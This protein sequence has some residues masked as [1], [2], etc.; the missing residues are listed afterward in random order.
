M[1]NAVLAAAPLPVT[2]AARRNQKAFSSRS[3][4]AVKQLK[5]LHHRLGGEYVLFRVTPAHQCKVHCSAGL[6]RHMQLVSRFISPCAAQLQAFLKN[7]PQEAATPAVQPATAGA[8]G[9]DEGPAPA[10]GADAPAADPH[11]ATEVAAQQPAAPRATA[12]Q[13]RLRASRQ[14]R[15]ALTLAGGQLE[16]ASKAQLRQL[17]E[18]ESGGPMPLGFTARQLRE[19]LQQMQQ[20]HLT[21]VLVNVWQIASTLQAHVGQSHAYL[22]VALGCA[23]TYTLR[24][25]GR[26]GCSSWRRRGRY[27]SSHRHCVTLPTTVIDAGR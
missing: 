17:Y 20:D 11:A 3:K 27:S 19:V 22:C 14:S 5:P 6:R 21:G 2:D 13:Q 4:R 23:K 9:Q 1:V 25:R 10:A 26:R 16:A 8:S 12:R 24:C 7:G 15:P 18:A